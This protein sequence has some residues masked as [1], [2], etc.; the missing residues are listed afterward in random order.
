VANIVRQLTPRR[1]VHRYTRDF[2]GFDA[3]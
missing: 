2:D 3:G 1:P